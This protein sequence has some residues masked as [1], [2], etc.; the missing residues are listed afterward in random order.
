MVDICIMKK[1]SVLVLTCCLTVS[2]FAQKSKEQKKSGIDKSKYS[3]Y[4]GLGGLLGGIN[5]AN[6]YYGIDKH[7][8]KNR[9]MILGGG[10]R[11]SYLGNKDVTYI[12]APAKYTSDNKTVDSLTLDGGSLVSA[13]IFGNIGYNLTSKLQLGFNIEFL[14]ISF[15]G[16]RTGK[17]VDTGYAITQVFPAKPTTGNVLLIGD[18]DLGTVGSELYVQYK[19]LPNFSA[20]LGGSFQFSEYTTVNNAQVISAGVYNNRFR[21]KAQGISFGIQY[22]F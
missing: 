13:N 4:A 11:L 18:N 12:T 5:G 22:H 9:K 19:V 14:G 16:E 15:G 8:L 20:R 10:F 3:S 6:V 7:V 21:Q 2:A 17:F 1:F